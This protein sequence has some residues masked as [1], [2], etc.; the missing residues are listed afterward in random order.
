MWLRKPSATAEE[1]A[2]LRSEISRELNLPI[3][4]EG[5][6]KWVVSLNSKIDPRV[7]VLNR[8]YGIC[9]D[10]T[11]KVRR[12]YLRRHDTLGIVRQCQEEMVQVF[13]KASNSSEF[14]LL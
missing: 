13:S 11:V 10:G 2:E 14:K 8:Y 1:Y 7:P 9:Q 4:F 12:I 5:I 3:S 6:Y